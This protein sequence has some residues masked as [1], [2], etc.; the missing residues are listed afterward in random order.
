[1]S[2]ITLNIIAEHY[3]KE[4]CDEFR[5]EYNKQ[6]KD[7][8]QTGREEMIFNLIFFAYL[9][10]HELGAARVFGPPDKAKLWQPIESY[11]DEGMESVEL[12][13]VNPIDPHQMRKEMYCMYDSERRIWTDR[14]GQHIEWTPTHWQESDLG[15]EEP[16][17]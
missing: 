4:K 5:K 12:W 14:N 8:T 7:L 16:S 9:K 10:G 11:M 13:L 6:A 3:A 17:D 15:P 2:D 1:M